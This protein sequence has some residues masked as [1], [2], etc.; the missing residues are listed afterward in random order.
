MDSLSRLLDVVPDAQQTDE[1]KD[2]EFGSYCF[3]E[4]EPAKILE[5]VAT[6]VIE[7]HVRTGEL[8]DCSQK[9]QKLTK[10][11]GCNEEVTE[12]RKEMTRMQEETS[13]FSKYS[14]KLVDIGQSEH[15]WAQ[16]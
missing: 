6:E 8:I 2:H 1:P 12:I 14:Q 13:E 5:T 9:L 10:V 16:L 7:P 15:I 3:E 11:N 4:L